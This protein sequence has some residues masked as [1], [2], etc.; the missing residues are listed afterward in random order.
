MRIWRILSGVLSII[1]FLVI[2]VQSFAAGV[3][4]TLVA[5]GESSGSVGVI[6]AILMLVGGIVSLVLN[7]SKSKGGDIALIVIYGIFAVLAFFGH[8]SIYKDLIVWG[9]WAVICIVFA[10]IDFQSKKND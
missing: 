7:N 9:I 1:L 4:N 2:L 3:A 10:F 8:G 6:C 5:N